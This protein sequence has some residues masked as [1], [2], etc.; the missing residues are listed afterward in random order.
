MTAV[1]DDLE[2]SGRTDPGPTSPPRRDAPGEPAGGLFEATSRIVRQ[3]ASILEEEIAAGVVAAKMVEKKF[4]DVD[5]L[6]AGDPS[7]VIQRFRRDTH[8]VVDI[9]LDLA[10]VATRSLGDVASRAVRLAPGWTTSYVTPKPSPDAAPPTPTLTMPVPVSPGSSSE[11]VMNVENDT[12]AAV[13][14]FEFHGTDLIDEE[15]HRIPAN[16][17]TFSRDSFSVGPHQTEKVAIRVAVPK[18]TPA[19][20]YSGLIQASRVKSLKAILVV[21]IA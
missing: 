11:V 20:L 9:F 15:G 14:A 6:R 16:K 3:A 4:V 17:V 12:N 19:G 10:H 21:E 2:A 13:E 18:G 7:E 1:P 5:A 8:E